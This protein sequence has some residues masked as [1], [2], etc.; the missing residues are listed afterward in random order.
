MT[1]RHADIK[2]KLTYYVLPRSSGRRQRAHDGVVVTLKSNLRWSL[3]PAPSAAGTGAQV[4]VASGLDL[5]PSGD[6]ATLE[7]LE[8]RELPGV[9]ALEQ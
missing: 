6:G 9:K 3:T 5:R 8:G 2:V 1:R 4:Q 7:F